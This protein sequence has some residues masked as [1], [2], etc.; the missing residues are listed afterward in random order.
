MVHLLY[1]LLSHKPTCLV[2]ILFHNHDNDN[3]V[4]LIR[5]LLAI[6]LIVFER[7]KV[8][9][10]SVR[11]IRNIFYSMT[12]RTLSINVCQNTLVMAI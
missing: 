9:I 5:K 7:Y 3:K 11:G 2:D 12:C 4:E 6:S 8:V 1:L 10:Y